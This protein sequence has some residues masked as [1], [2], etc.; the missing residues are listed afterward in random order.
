MIH[1]WLTNYWTK[2]E[3]QDFY[4]DS[5]YA[6]EPLE[7]VYNKKKVASKVNE[8][9]YKKRPLTEE[10][11]SN[12]REKSKVR[13]RVEHIFGFV[14]NSMNGSYIRTIGMA[15]AEAKIGMMNIVYNICRCVQL[16]KVV[17]MGQLCAIQT[18]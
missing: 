9:G 17:T 10:Q 1:R 12:N 4:E 5:A 7:Q 18:K 3:G 13:A 16:K 2:Q 11:K 15:R 8:K 6:G 14:E